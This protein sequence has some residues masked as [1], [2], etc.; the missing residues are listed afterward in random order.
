MMVA[1]VSYEKSRHCS[2]R[3]SS[4]TQ[5]PGRYMRHFLSRFVPASSDSPASL[6][7]KGR[8]RRYI[9]A[10]FCAPFRPGVGRPCP[11]Q[12]RTRKQPPLAWQQ[13]ALRVVS[14]AGTIFCVS[15]KRTASTSVE[16]RVRRFGVASELRCAWYASGVAGALPSDGGDRGLGIAGQ[17]AEPPEAPRPLCAGEVEGAVA[18]CEAQVRL[19]Q[20]NGVASAVTRAAGPAAAGKAVCMPTPP[21]TGPPAGPATASAQAGVAARVFNSRVAPRVV[22]PTAAAGLLPAIAAVLAR[23]FA[24]AIRLSTR[25]APQPRRRAGLLPPPSAFVPVAF[26]APF[27]AFVSA[28]VS[29]AF[30]AAG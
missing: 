25:A 27:C 11:P 18:A 13:T 2:Q 4:A 12:K 21:I 6:S 20:P 30:G 7:A 5:A 15:Y 22:S 29:S 28:Q 14:L 26:Q 10:G 9:F 19:A 8:Q 17:P 23:H 16:S 1:K 3:V 24:Y